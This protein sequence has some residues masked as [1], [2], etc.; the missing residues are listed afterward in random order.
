MST[1]TR[2]IFTTCSPT[3]E[4]IVISQDWT[5]SSFSAASGCV[6]V[7]TNGELIQ[8]RDSKN[9]DEGEL[10]YNQQE[11]AAFLAGVKAGEFDL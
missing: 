4:V 2:S 11:W 1:S 10:T 8:V 5:K 7:R 3:S 9:P 6:Q